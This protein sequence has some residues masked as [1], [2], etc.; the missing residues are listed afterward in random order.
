MAPA[1]KTLRA[2][3]AQESKQHEPANQQ[4]WTVNKNSVLKTLIPGII[5]APASS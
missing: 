1:F 5:P 2:I 4:L 3:T